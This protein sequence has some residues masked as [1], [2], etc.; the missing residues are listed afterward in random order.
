MAESNPQLRCASCPYWTRVGADEYT[1]ECHHVSSAT[2]TIKAVPRY[3]AWWCSEH[4]LAPEQRDR[5]AAQL[6]QA[7][8]SNPEWMRIFRQWNLVSTTVEHAYALTDALRTR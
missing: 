8:Y 1:G 3:H 2:Q 4:P 5:L 7:L 6:A